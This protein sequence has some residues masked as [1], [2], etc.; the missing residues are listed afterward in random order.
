MAKKRK[1]FFFFSNAQ[2]AT[3]LAV[4]GAILIF[5]V[6]FLIRS[7]MNFNYG[8]QAPLQAM[9]LAL[10]ESF[11]SGQRRET[12]RNTAS[13]LFIDDRKD[14]DVGTGPGARLG[15]GG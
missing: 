11:L 1:K 6:G 5:A 3:E 7:A 10:R 14:V 2:T 15:G 12:S 4:F 8:Q 13:V 9:R